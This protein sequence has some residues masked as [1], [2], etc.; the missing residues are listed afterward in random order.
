[1]QKDSWPEAGQ[2]KKIV[3][4]RLANAKRWL[5]RGWPMQKDSWPEA[6]QCKRVVD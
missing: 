6:G 4:Q 5:A 1:M 3:G 2:C